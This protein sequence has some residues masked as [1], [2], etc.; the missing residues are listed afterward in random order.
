MGRITTMQNEIG[1]LQSV[2]AERKRQVANLQE[3]LSTAKSEARAA[4]AALKN[5]KDRISELENQKPAAA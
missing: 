3:Q 5:A 1:H 2:L 4:E